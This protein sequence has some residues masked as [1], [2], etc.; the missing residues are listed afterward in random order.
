MFAISQLCY[1]HMCYAIYIFVPRIRNGSE[2]YRGI[3]CWRKIIHVDCFQD[4]IWWIFQ[5][6]R[7]LQTCCKYE[8]N[9]LHLIADLI[10]CMKNWKY[11]YTLFA[12]FELLVS[13]RTNPIRKS[14]FWVPVPL[15]PANTGTSAPSWLNLV[16][17]ILLCW[18]AEM[19][20]YPRY[21]LIEI[22]HMLKFWI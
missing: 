18:T 6:L 13:R 11:T 8:L 21:A 22:T 7:F 1:I 16:Q 5:E 19:G 9:G 14:L 4:Y 20:P 2:S 12:T 3:Y 15:C 17:T 10:M